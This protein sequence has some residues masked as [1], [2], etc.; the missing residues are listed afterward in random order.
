GL[1]MGGVHGPAVLVAQEVLEQDAQRVGQGG[2]IADA[3]LDERVE[4]VELDLAAADR[5]LCLA[6]E[7]VRLRRHGGFPNLSGCG[8]TRGAVSRPL[9][10]DASAVA[11]I[12]AAIAAAPL[13]AFDLEFLAQDRRAAALCLGAVASGGRP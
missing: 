5:D 4:P 8:E 6:G 3:G 7:A 12:A 13:V 2:D 10:H 11:A 9:E 1:D